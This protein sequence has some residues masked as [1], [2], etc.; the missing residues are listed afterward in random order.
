VDQMQ[1]G[2]PEPSIPSSEG[3]S[4]INPTNNNPR[5]RPIIASASE[6]P[7]PISSQRS[8][9]VSFVVRTLNHT[10]HAIPNAHK[11]IP[12]QSATL[13]SGT[14]G[15][16][17]RPWQSLAIMTHRCLILSRI[18]YDTTAPIRAPSP[19]HATIQRFT[20]VS[21]G[22]CPSLLVNGVPLVV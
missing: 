4:G 21:A 7:P 9:R 20:P 10:K 3:L 15:A 11:P 5:M 2:M 8:R 22:D 16:L 17:S 1:D 14:G 19:A 6:K 18:Q 13:S 12:I